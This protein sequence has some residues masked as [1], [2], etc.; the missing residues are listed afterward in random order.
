[1]WQAKNFWQ[2]ITRSLSQLLTDSFSSAH[3]PVGVA[4][5]LFLRMYSVNTPS[6]SKCSEAAERFMSYEP[7]GTPNDLNVA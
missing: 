5:M 1:M 2:D 7:L 6:R 4:E 3:I